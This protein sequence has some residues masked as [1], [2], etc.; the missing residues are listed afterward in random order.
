MDGDGR[1]PRAVMTAV[2]AL[3]I[4]SICSGVRFLLSS[5]WVR[6]VVRTGSII[7]TIH[8]WETSA[9][10]GCFALQD[11]Q[12]RSYFYQARGGPFLS[13]RVPHATC[14]VLRLQ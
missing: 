8:T 2:L 10:A 6:H 11:T 4:Y 1:G 13:Q 12:L 3:V 9:L 7:S 5:L 14:H